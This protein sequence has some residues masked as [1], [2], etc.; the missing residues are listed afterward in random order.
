[1]LGGV[2]ASERAQERHEFGAILGAELDASEIGRETWAI[3]Q[4][5]GV[6]VDHVLDGPQRAVMH[7]WCALVDV[8]Q[9]RG[10]EGESELLD[11]GHHARAAFIVAPNADVVKAI[12]G[13]A[14]S[15]VAG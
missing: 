10:L 2:L 13:E 12:I 15:G 7:V 9:C 1:M 5:R 3:D 14:P 11:A 8:A 4:A 6:K